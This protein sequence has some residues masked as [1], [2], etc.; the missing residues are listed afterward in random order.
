MALG[1]LGK[2]FSFDDGGRGAQAPSRVVRDAS[3]RTW[4]KTFDAGRV[5]RQPGRP[6]SPSL[7]RLTVVLVY[8]SVVMTCLSVV[9]ARRA[10]NFLSRQMDLGCLTVVLEYLAIDL[11]CM[12]AVTALLTLVL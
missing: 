5:E 11:A 12:A 7:V 2:R 3:S 4:G 10:A 1:G 8:L 6:R 9:L